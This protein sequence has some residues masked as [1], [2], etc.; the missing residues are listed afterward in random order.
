VIPSPYRLFSPPGLDVVLETGARSSELRNPF[1]YQVRA[2]GDLF[3]SNFQ[4][5]V[6]SD[7]RGTPAAAT[8]LLQRRSIEGRLFG[9]LHGR[10]LSLGDVYTP[11]LPLGGRSAGGRGFSFSTVPLSQSSVFNRIDIRG[12]L[13]PN[14]DVELYVNDV[15][16]GS[17]NQSANGR[18]EFLDVPLS[19]GLNVIRTVTYGPRG[20]R[21]EEVQIINVG[22]GLLKRGDV[23]F[24]FGLVDQD[25]PVFDLSP[26]QEDEGRD[27]LGNAR[28]VRAIGTVN[29]GLAEFLTL[30][31]GAALTPRSEGGSTGIYALGARTSLF[32]LATQVDGAYD[33]RGG[34]AASI[35]FAGQFHGV[36]GVVRHAEYTGGFRDENNLGGNTSLD[37]QRR[38][39]LT[40]DS[41]IGLRGRILPVSLRA[42]RNSYTDGSYDVTATGRVSTSMAGVLFSTGLEYGRTAYRPARPTETLSG[43]I[44]ASTFASYKWQIRASLDYEFL[45]D[46]V[47][48]NF[49]A[50][51][52]RRIRDN[53]IARL[54]IGQALDDLSATDVVLSSILAT[55]Y[56][57]LALTGEYDNGE[58]DWRLSAQWSF[59]LGYNPLDKRY[60]LTRMGPGS[61]G[62]VVFDA[63]MDVN[64]NGVRDA[65]EAPVPD[66]VVLGGGQTQS[67]TGANGGVFVSGV[68]GGPTARLDVNLE[69]VDITS[70]QS[71]PTAIEVRPRAGSVTRVNYPLRPTGDV[72]VKLELVR[73]DGK[74]VGLSA[75]RAQLVP[76]KGGPVEAVTEFDGS[77]LFTALPVGVYRL[78][79]DPDQA[80]KLRMRLTE[81]PVIEIKGDGSFTP[82]VDAE[83][84]FDD[85]PEVAGSPSAAG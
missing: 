84:K 9:P 21:T 35:G 80:K 50:S 6:A 26:A 39:E 67:V 36:A 28:G 59:G 3:Y 62:S 56:G 66:V 64:G 43:Y 41:N 78:Q 48:R 49:T 12:D 31:A 2:G 14:H 29:Y 53:W 85:A 37:L 42:V 40:L 68:G 81:A 8:V 70:V 5:Y 17:T 58:R 23:T 13:S 63:Y 25:R 20:E 19:P 71:P 73:D 74:R 22:A 52:D 54:A 55:R 33:S 79:L 15:L 24:E 77:A 44:T 69:K 60:Q 7:E 30:S 27:V 16:R 47:V 1:Q 38:T 51:V 72:M 10:E 34:S 18:Y 4:G 82:D 46:L 45:P 75:V 65:D 61:G 76:E 83:V 57:D 11:G 32:G